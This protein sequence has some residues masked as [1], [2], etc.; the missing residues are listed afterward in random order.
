MAACECFDGL[1]VTSAD[2]FACLVYQ[3]HMLNL[4]GQSGVKHGKYIFTNQSVFQFSPHK[5]IFVV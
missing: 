3:F 2:S 4:N 5:K 1:S